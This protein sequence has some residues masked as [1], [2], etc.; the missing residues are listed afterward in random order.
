MLFLF[1]LVFMPLKN[2]NQFLCKLIAFWKGAGGIQKRYG[3]GVETISF[4]V[5][6]HILVNG[7][8]ISKSACRES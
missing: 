1:S 2:Q 8:I 3:F 4:C 6:N 7:G 5:I